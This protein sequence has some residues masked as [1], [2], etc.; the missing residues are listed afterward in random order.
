LKGPYFGNSNTKI[1][2]DLNKTKPQCKINGVK[3][4]YKKYFDPD[5]LEQALKEGYKKCRC[6]S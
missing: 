5:T 1:V 3:P 6:V 2:H 4:K